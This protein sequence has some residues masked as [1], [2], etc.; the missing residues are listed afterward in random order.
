MRVLGEDITQPGLIDNNCQIPT[1][2]ADFTV[3][4]QLGPSNVDAAIAQLRPGAM[5]ADRVYRGHRRSKQCGGGARCRDERRQ[6]RAHHR[7]YHGDDQFD[8]YERQRPVPGGLRAG[9]EI[10]RQFHQSGGH[11]PQA[12]SALAEIPAL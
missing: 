1:I 4:P 8:Q 5:D 6:E 2:V 7:V 11:R 3:A 9:K 10:C 12:T